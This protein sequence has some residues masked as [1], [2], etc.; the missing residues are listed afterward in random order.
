M[1]TKLNLKSNDDLWDRVKMYKIKNKCDSMNDA[2]LQLIE[3]GL[4]K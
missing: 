2:V 1:Q 3:K 4:K